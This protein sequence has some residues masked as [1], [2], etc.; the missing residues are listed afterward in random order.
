MTHNQTWCLSNRA[1]QGYVQ[2][3]GFF[4]AFWIRL[5]IGANDGADKCIHFGTKMSHLSGQ[6]FN[7]NWVLLISECHPFYQDIQSIVVIIQG[8]LCVYHTRN[9]VAIMQGI[10]GY[11]T[12]H[13][14]GYHTRNMVAIIRGIC[15]YHTRNTRFFSFTRHLTIAWILQS[16]TNVN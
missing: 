11:H 13:Y 6:F 16:E 10:C 7:V 2:T 12:G 3:N 1:F 14:G 15:G 5:N 9:M 4:C 8:I